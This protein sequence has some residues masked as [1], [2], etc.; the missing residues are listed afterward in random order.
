MFYK[1]RFIRAI[2]LEH[3]TQHKNYKNNKMTATF[4]DNSQTRQWINP[5]GKL[6]S[7]LNGTL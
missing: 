7:D 4:P 3:S 6:A 1:G 5:T 2:L